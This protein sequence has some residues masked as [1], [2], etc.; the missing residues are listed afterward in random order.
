MKT[1]PDT[2]A[3]QWAPE[4]LRG[5][6]FGL[7]NLATGIAIL[8]AS[9][10]AGVLWDCQGPS[11]CFIAGGAFAAVTVVLSLAARSVSSGGKRA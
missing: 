3:T 2:P 9:V 6:A 7:F 11:A 10:I 1:G 5:S 8:A 4:G